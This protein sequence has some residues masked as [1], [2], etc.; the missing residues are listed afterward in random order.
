MSADSPPPVITFFGHRLQSWRR[1]GLVVRLRLETDDGSMVQELSENEW[2]DCLRDLGQTERAALMNL[3][4]R[5]A[6]IAID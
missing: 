5:T 1:N 2:A 3:Y 6:T 4:N